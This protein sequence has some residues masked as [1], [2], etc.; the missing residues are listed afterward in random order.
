MLENGKLYEKSV[1]ETAVE[2]FAMISIIERVKRSLENIKEVA[3]IVGI[4]DDV[5]GDFDKEFNDLVNMAD[6]TDEWFKKMRALEASILET[7]K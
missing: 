2:E 1:F 5:I 3:S 7:L 6:A 4:S